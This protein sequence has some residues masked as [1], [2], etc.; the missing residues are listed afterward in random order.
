MAGERETMSHARLV[1]RASSTKRM[2]WT[3]AAAL[4]AVLLGAGCG[5]EKAA[6]PP[7][8]PVVPVRVATAISKTVPVQVRAIGTGEAFSAVSIKSQVNAELME[9]HFQEGQFVKRG[10]LLFTLDR[11]PF[12]AAVNQAQANLARDQA[13]EALAEVQARRYTKLFEEAVVPKEQAD[14]MQANADALK[15]A[16]LADKAA[17]DYT[18]LQL[19]YCSIYSPLDGR[20]GSLM[21]HVGNLVKAND[22]PVLV[23]INQITPIY[24]YFSP[25]ENVLPEV[26]KYM[27][28]GRR[29]RVQAFLPD[30]TQHPEEGFLSFV[31]NAVDN[32]TGTIRLK[33]TFANTNRRLWP[34]QFG[35]VVLTLSEQPNAVLI[36]SQAVQTGQTGPFVFVVKTDQTVELRAVVTSRSYEGSAIVDKGVTAGEVVVIDGQSSLVPG[37]HVQVKAGSPGS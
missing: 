30:D 29:L 19:E 35:D 13:Q 11:R 14:Q 26:K 36:P 18:K 15:A 37:I 10:D 3:I 6:A 21:V 5:K 20:T 27:V 33:G 12:D 7:S 32:T 24:V 25:P 17:V 1:N 16:V 9:V 8:V 31:D 2:G 22:V 4:A 34:G 23:V 28:M